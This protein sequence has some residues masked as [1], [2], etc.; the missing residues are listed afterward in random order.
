MYIERIQVEEGF[1]DGLDVTFSPG[2]N[3]VIGA[4]GTG[5]T[6][7]IELLRFCLGAE[8]SSEVVRRSRDH[9]LSVLAAGQVTVT[10]NNQGERIFVSRT[11]HDPEPRANGWYE[12]PMVFAQTEIETVGLES[13]GRLRLIDGFSARQST[14]SVDEDQIAAEVRSIT[15]EIDRNRREIEDLDKQISL[16][17]TIVAEFNANE[18]ARQAVAQS[19]SGLESKASA[20][21]ML[22]ATISNAAIIASQF[23]RLKNDTG[24]WYNEVKSAVESSVGTQLRS[25]A[26]LVTYKLR[27][28]AIVAQF[29]ESLG[30]IA[31]IYHELDANEKKSLDSKLKAENSARQ[32]R[33]EVEALQAGSG[34]VM[35][36]AQEIAER[37]ARIGVMETTN[38]SKKFQ[39]QQ[40]IARRS[41]LLENLDRLRK[42]RF[43][44]RT[45]II[46][47]L[48]SAL[49]PNIRIIIRRNGQH[50]IFANAL[51]ES[52]RKS[53]LKYGEVVP[54]IAENISP[55]A[56]LD[57]VENFDFE[58]ISEA[59]GISIDRASRILSHLRTSDLGTLSTID[60]EDEVVFQLLDGRDYK[61]LQDL[62]TGQRCTVILPLVL[63][64][65]DRILIV[66]QPEDHI[67]NAFIASTLIK[68]VLART[69]NS[70]IIFSTHNPNIPVLGEADTVLHL[71]SDGRRGFT[72]SAGSLSDENVVSSISTVMEGGAEA[73][74]RRAHFYMRMR[75]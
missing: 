12:R 10:L 75:V 70:Q 27:L 35:R 46:E 13:T 17:P 57:A 56:L 44:E 34:Q 6:S 36:K 63:A 25:D 69:K 60:I 59:A 53:G 73:F 51:S 42:Q 3:V 8:G 55:R 61:D 71:G 2:L 7:L 45:E 23:A 16:K 31:E 49:A 74:K 4:R 30:K 54:A 1:L 22:S 38:S 67:D 29:T 9:A 21:E 40:L 5:K 43:D 24:T 65:H 62:S 66:D 19:S 14:T 32:M 11:A 33:S 58:L 37:M 39:L 41:A 72:L 18:V 64:H 48:N 26:Y 28:D 15:S 50:S 20:L 52:L 68:A 47:K